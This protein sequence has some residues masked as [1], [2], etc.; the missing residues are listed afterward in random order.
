VF[1]GGGEHG[2]AGDKDRDDEGEE[3][4]VGL[5]RGWFERVRAEVVS[6]RKTKEG[7]R[8]T[9]RKIEDGSLK[10]RANGHLGRG[11][12]HRPPPHSLYRGGDP[13]R[14]HTS[15]RIMQRT[16]RACRGMSKRR[17]RW[18]FGVAW[19]LSIACWQVVN[20]NAGCCRR[21]R[22]SSQLS[23]S[24]PVESALR[25]CSQ[26]GLTHLVTEAL[27]GRH[28]PDPR[29]LFRPAC[30]NDNVELLKEFVT[31]AASQ[32]SSENIS[33]SNPQLN[34]AQRCGEVEEYS[35]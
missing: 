1:T 21:D 5:R 3:A 20:D 12:V 31:V 35:D 18:H 9:E 17:Y 2:A 22:V 26:S 16:G 27:W 11:F 15:S 8:S 19:K 29:V 13:G 14:C 28:E 30:Q 34:P 25:I 6:G 32:F 7:V 10:S 24:P 33:Y 23:L 4:H